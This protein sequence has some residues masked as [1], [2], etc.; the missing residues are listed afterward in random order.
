[1]KTGEGQQ[2]HHGPVTATG[3]S[4]G[5][6]TITAAD[7]I[8]VR[9]VLAERLADALE[10]IADFVRAAESDAVSREEFHA[11]MIRARAAVKPVPGAEIERKVPR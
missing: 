10:I 6:A 8:A 11:L 3:E 2:L 4:S 1:M 7:R 5:V 9:D